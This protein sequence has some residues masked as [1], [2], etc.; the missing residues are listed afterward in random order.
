MPHFTTC[1]L[2]FL[3]W[4]RIWLYKLILTCLWHYVHLALDGD[5]THDLSALPLDHSWKKFLT[6][7]NKI[8]VLSYVVVVNEI[9]AKTK[10]DEERSISSQKRIL[11]TFRKGCKRS[12]NF[13]NKV[14]EMFTANII[15]LFQCCRWKSYCT[16]QN[17][18]WNLPSISSTLNPRIFRTKRSSFKVLDVKLEKRRSFEKLVRK[19]LMKLTPVMA[20]ITQ[21]GQGNN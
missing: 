17:S 5:W 4:T 6:C 8:W 9:T 13:D 10:L 2:I 15:F 12:E 20:L 11:V 16:K 1:F 14:D 19:T 7:W 21:L 3:Y 18:K